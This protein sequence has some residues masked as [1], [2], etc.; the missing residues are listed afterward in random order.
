VTFPIDGETMLEE[1]GKQGSIIG[2][3][4]CTFPSQED[5]KTGGGGKIGYQRGRSKGGNGGQGLERNIVGVDKIKWGKQ[6][7]VKSNLRRRALYEN[8][9]VVYITEGDDER[10]NN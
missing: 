6:R 5:N 3:C 4:A 9:G 10:R 8:L 7:M 1:R 2:W